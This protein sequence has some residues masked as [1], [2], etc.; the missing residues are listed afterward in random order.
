VRKTVNSLAL[1]LA[2]NFVVLLVI[3]AALHGA[4]AASAG[5][6]LGAAALFGILNTLLKPVVRL[7]TAPLAVLTLGLAWFGVALLM[8]VIT[9]VLVDGFDI[10][11]L[12]TYLW[13]TIIAWAVNLA[14]DVMPGRFRGTRR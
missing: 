6:L 12:T 9:D 1:S 10:D 14:L 8:L 11:G 2:A 3:V 7:L 13:A 4:T 5:A